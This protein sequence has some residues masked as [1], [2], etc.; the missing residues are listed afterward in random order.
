[1]LDYL[2]EKLGVSETSAKQYI[3]PSV[4][5][6]PIA[7]LLM[8]EIIKPFEHGWIVVNEAQA[9]SMLIRKTER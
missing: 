4:L 5:G 3:K 1:M 2:I 8:A 6:K 7:D 9:S